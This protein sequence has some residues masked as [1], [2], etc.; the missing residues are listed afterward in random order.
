MA[1]KEEGGG[2]GLG[3]IIV[4]IGI[5][6]LLGLF[7]AF[8]GGPDRLSSQG[9]PFL[10]PPAPLSSGQPYSLSAAEPWRK[11]SNATFGVRTT[12]TLGTNSG[13]QAGTYGQTENVEYELSGIQNQVDTLSD[14]VTYQ[15]IFGTPSPHRGKI[16]F[17]T[18]SLTTAKSTSNRTEYLTIRANDSNSSSIP[19]TGWRVVSAIRN[20]D[21]STQEA[22][23]GNASQMPVVGEINPVYGVSLEPG[24]VAYLVTGAS[25]FG[26]SFKVN[27]CSGYLSQ[28]QEYTP[29]LTRACPLPIDDIRLTDQKIPYLNACDDYLRSLPQCTA[30]F[31]PTPKEYGTECDQFIK[32]ELTYNGC[33]DNHRFRPQ[34]Y[35]KEWR[36]FLNKQNELWRN[37]REVIKLLDNEG[38]TVDMMSY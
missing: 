1:D 30:I 8:T 16:S 22:F 11:L 4:F 5:L 38:K 25:P 21:G 26:V 35:T 37:K 12:N 23:V 34:F 15:S 32:K 10:Q 2:R 31:S 18:S 28:F 13:A 27:K 6:G 24:G 20:K 19:I 7:W 33:I 29:T 36:I 17:D 14:E 3:D 9:G